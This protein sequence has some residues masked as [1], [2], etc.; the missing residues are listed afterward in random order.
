MK[1]FEVEIKDF[2]NHHHIPFTDNTGS[3]NALDFSLPD[4]DL[5]FDA[6]EKKQ[7]INLDN[8]R[9]S[10][11]PEEHFFILD[12]LAA[13]KILLKAPRSFLLIR[14]NVT[15]PAYYVFSIVDLLC[16]PKRRVRRRLDT[17]KEI[18]KGKWYIDL[19]YGRKTS[20]LNDG[21]ASMMNYTELFPNVFQDHID[22]WGSYE[23]ENI[24]TTGTPRKHRYWDI[25]LKGK[26]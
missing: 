17:G 18:F 22:C 2:L 7:H 25:D 13:R 3:L 1:S 24:I 8:W 15:G 12:D 20:S 16:M 10:S 26:Q 11:V 5:H 23:G 4:V 21:Y 19:R 14:D 9:D 6:K